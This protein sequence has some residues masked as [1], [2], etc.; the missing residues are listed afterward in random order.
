[1]ISGTSNAAQPVVQLT[2]VR[3][4][5]DGTTAVDGLSLSIG[6]GEVLALLGPNG[7]G[8]TTTVEMCE[9]FVVPDSGTVRI[10]GLDPIAESA[11]LRPRIGVMLQGGGAYPGSKAGEM[12]E[13]VASY[14]ADPLDTTWLLDCLGLTSAVRTPY[15]RLSGGQ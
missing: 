14:S 7:A 8:K 11:Q 9:G 2:D 12:L 5:Y 10:L 6:A 1:M 4:S 3:K 13:L 15:R